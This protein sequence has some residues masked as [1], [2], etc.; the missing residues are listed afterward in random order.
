[1]NDNKYPNY[2]LN[3]N[4]TTFRKIQNKY[5]KIKKL[6]SISIIII[7][8]ISMILSK[9]SIFKISWLTGIALICF[10]MGIFLSEKSEEI[11]T[12][13][14]FQFFNDYLILIKFNNYYGKNKIRREYFK[15]QYKDITG[16]KFLV[17][18]SSKRIYMYGKNVHIVFYNLNKDGSLPEKATYDK[19]KSKN[20]IYFTTYQ[21]NNI[22]FVKEIEKHSPLKLE[23]TK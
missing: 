16:C 13:A 1:M 3:F 7:V 8:I 17:N 11:I 14:Q 18:T 15:I 19:I 4:D 6:T 5:S 10:A 12:P 2:V 23:I 22:D 20:L 21:N 9:L